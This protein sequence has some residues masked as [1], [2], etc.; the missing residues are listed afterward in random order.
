MVHF[1]SCRSR[2]ARN[3]QLA[4]RQAT[5]VVGHPEH[6]VLP[7]GR[8]DAGLP[9]MNGFRAPV[10]G[11]PNVRNWAMRDY[12]NRVAVWRMMKVLANHGIRGT[13]ALNSDVCKHHPGDHGSRNGKWLGVHGALPDQRGATERNASRGRTR[14]DS[15]HAGDNRTRHGQEACGLARRGP[16]RKTWNTLDH[17]IAEGVDYIADWTS[18][19]LPFPDDGRRQAD[20][21]NSVHTAMQ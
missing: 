10:R 18:D 13:T 1:H 15:R 9:A 5:G 11:F 20:H 6:R 12:G 8:P 7:S 17:L 16:G 14:G 3:F 2:G 4:G 19:D 21:V